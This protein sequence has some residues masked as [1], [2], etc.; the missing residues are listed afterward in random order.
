MVATSAL[1]KYLIMGGNEGRRSPEQ[2]S[3]WM[4]PLLENGSWLELGL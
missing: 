2:L 1:F 4:S 3:T